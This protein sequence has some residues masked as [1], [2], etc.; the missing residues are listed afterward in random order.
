MG[1]AFGAAGRGRDGKGIFDVSP[2]GQGSRGSI[3]EE[4]VSGPAAVMCNVGR[5]G[6]SSATMS[7]AAAA[8]VLEQ[9]KERAARHLSVRST[10]Y[11]RGGAGPADGERER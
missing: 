4:R 10:A 3:T 9:Q 6:W 7:R 11:P 1:T 5:T 2:E 8:G